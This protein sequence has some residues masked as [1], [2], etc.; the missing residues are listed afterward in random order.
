M[1]QLYLKVTVQAI[2][3]YNE[4]IQSSKPFTNVVIVGYHK[5]D[6]II[7]WRNVMALYLNV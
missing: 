1:F 3:N 2:E 5:L 4:N 6:S 7:S